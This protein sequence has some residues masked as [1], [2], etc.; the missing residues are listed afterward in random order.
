MYWLMGSF[1]R[2]SNVAIR[3]YAEAATLVYTVHM[4]RFKLSMERLL[5][6]MLAKQCRE[7]R[8]FNG[9]DAGDA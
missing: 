1:Y 4:V 3:V 9:R 2:K 8:A 5:E 6:I 7:R